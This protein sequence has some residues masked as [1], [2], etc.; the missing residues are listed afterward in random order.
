M[1]FGVK[2]VF[3]EGGPSV[4]G[5]LEVMAG[6]GVGT[7]EG[8]GLGEWRVDPRGVN[9]S[10]SGCTSPCGVLWAVFRAPFPPR[11]CETP[12]PSWSN[13]SETSNTSSVSQGIFL[14]VKV[15]FTVKTAIEANREN[16]VSVST[17]D[18]NG[19]AGGFLS[20]ISA[21]ALAIITI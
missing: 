6:A 17:F 7:R 2:E 10:P 11:P 8:G 3:L 5:Q 13:S 1:S 9:S 21:S 12:Q 4:G 14:V 16:N 19:K 20:A 18:K 15:V